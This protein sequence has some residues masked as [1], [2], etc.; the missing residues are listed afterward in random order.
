MTEVSEYKVFA[1]KLLKWYGPNKRDLPWRNTKE[2]YKIWL[3]EIILQQ[4]RVDQGMAYY[5]KFVEAFPTVEELAQAPEATV[6]RL[7]Q[8]LGYYSRARNLHGSAKH[9]VKELGGKFP[10]SYDEIIKLKGVGD[11]TASAIASF[12]F[13]EPQAVVD[14]NVY[15]VLARVFGITEDISSSKGPKFF[16]S[17]AQKIIPTSNPAEYNQ[18]IMEFGSLQCTPKNPDC[19]HCIFSNECIANRSNLQDQL[20]IKSK[21][22]KTRNRHFNYLVIDYNNTF[23]FKER[24]MGDIWTGLYDFPLIESDQELDALEQILDN[25]PEGFTLTQSQFLSCQTMP[26]HILSHQKLFCKFWKFKIESPAAENMKNSFY[27]SFEIKNLPKPVLVDKY[28]NQS[29]F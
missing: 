24:P 2:P 26:K 18:A 20:P 7:W 23:V 15:R 11:Y 13:N 21:K 19:D 14:G 12:S 16:R 17:L 27:N 5:N 28:L 22:V 6:L 4:T 25:Q 3:S 8:G 29:I 1:S 9:I 10:N